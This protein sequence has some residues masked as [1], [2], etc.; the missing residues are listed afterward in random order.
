MA[1]DL[2]AVLIV[3]DGNRITDERNQKPR[4][5]EGRRHESADS[6]VSV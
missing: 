6:S 3:V 2:N 1:P 4:L 5:F